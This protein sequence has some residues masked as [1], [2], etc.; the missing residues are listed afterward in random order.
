[1]LDRA[2][3][4][5]RGQFMKQAEKTISKAHKEGRIA[6]RED[7]KVEY[8]S[9]GGEKSVGSLDDIAQ[10]LLDVMASYLM[11]KAGDLR[12]NP[13]SIGVTV[14]DIK[15]ILVEIRDKQK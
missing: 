6:F 2:M 5:A 4:F 11:D 13:A 1:M 15:G 7:D 12:A 9:K 14:E 3:K 8:T 10:R